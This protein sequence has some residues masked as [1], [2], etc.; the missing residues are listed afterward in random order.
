MGFGGPWG[1]YT[2][3]D[4]SDDPESEPKWTPRTPI[5]LFGLRY[6]DPATGRFL[7]RDPIGADG[8]LNLYEYAGDNPVSQADPDGLFHVYIEMAENGFG[9]GYVVADAG[10]ID[11][12]GE[13]C[14][15]GQLLYGPFP[16]S[17]RPSGG[18]APF[19]AGTWR[20][21]GMRRA[22]HFGE[23]AFVLSGSGE[24]QPWYRKT[25]LHGHP[26]FRRN[27]SKA[28]KAKKWLPEDWTWFTY[29]CERTTNQ[30]IYAIESL[31]YLNPTGDRLTHTVHKRLPSWRKAALPAWV[32]QPI[33][34]YCRAELGSS[35]LG[36]RRSSGRAIERPGVRWARGSARLAALSGVPGRTAPAEHPG[37]VRFDPG[38]GQIPRCAGR[39]RGR[40]R[41]PPAQ[42]PR[43]S[44]GGPS[45]HDQSL[46][47][48]PAPSAP[49]QRGR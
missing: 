27:K 9:Y 29:G 12:A 3:Q 6:Y 43:L 15:A 20:I 16:V 11:T 30:A 24:G 4:T 41:E 22:G 42:R 19:P 37:P 26:A 23:G 35:P 38:D 8:G 40:A 31:Y 7:N 33:R 28:K 21:T 17:N 44:A 36:T 47:V 45:S 46:A 5:V 32:C 25:W 49:L 34:W 39:L 18:H 13:L 2:D 1:G 14:S 10:D 48:T